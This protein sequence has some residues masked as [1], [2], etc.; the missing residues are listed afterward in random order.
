MPSGDFVYRISG[1]EFIPFDKNIVNYVHMPLDIVKYVDGIKKILQEQGFYYSYHADITSS[2]QR[3]SNISLEKTS[4]S[5]Y[6]IRDL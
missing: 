1:V 4:G 5:S 2:Q 3:H 6:Q